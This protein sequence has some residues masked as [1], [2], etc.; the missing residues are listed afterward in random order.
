MDTSDCCHEL[1][2]AEWLQDFRPIWDHWQS[3]LAELHQEGDDELE[4]SIS[5]S[6]KLRSLTQVALRQAWEATSYA[7]LWEQAFR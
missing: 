3:G 6:N 1:R 2:L 5:L 7:T 4:R